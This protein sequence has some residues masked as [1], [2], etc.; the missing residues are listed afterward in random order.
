MKRAFRFCLL[1]LLLLLPA[2]EADA[3]S[4][5]WALPPQYDELK[6]YS[7]DYYFCRLDGKWGLIDPRGRVV[8]P[9]AYDFIIPTA[10]NLGIFGVRSG[11]KYRL[12][13]IVKSSGEVL[14]LRREY[15]LTAYHTFSEHKLPVADAK[16][17]KGYL[18]DE[19]VEV[20]RCQFDVARPFREGFAATTSDRWVYY[21]T[22]SFDL[23]RRGSVLQIDFRNG[24]ITEGS[25]FRNGEAVIGYGDKYCV[26]NR[27]GEVL[28]PFRYSDWRVDRT[29]YT[30]LGPGETGQAAAS[31]E[32]QP[33][34]DPTITPFVRDG[35]YGYRSN[36]EV[37]VDAVFDRAGAFDRSGH[38]VAAIGGRQGILALIEG[39]YASELQASDGSSDVIRVER[40]HVIPACLCRLEVPEGAVD[41][42]IFAD[43]GTGRY[44][45]ITDSLTRSGNTF[46]GLIHPAPLR[47]ADSCIL[48]LR[49]SS[50]GLPVHAAE[51]RFAL[52]YL[53]RLRIYG[54][55]AATA[56]ADVD[57]DL[58]PVTATLHNDSNRPK[59]VTV[60]LTVDCRL[61]VPVSRTETVTIPA[62]GHVT[63]TVP[64]K[65]LRNE[66]A[67]ARVVASSGES[68]SNTVAL[69]ESY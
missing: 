58:Q 63:L 41:L 61:N 68:R 22:D 44:E 50:G 56:K 59:R 67:A 65:V 25:S 10:G 39:V 55:V 42:R 31:R 15:Y 30:I 43:R 47:N 36:G 5:V 35:R 60:T 4:V 46:S 40:G 12:S 7:A 13:G 2:L 52:E 18:N 16:G 20:V 64:V 3:R 54:P 48:K 45:E 37:V 21:I 17:R 69:R 51:R 38:A 29:D 28:R 62:N 6:P 14:L 66:T 11:T 1:F 26:I 23:D 32:P 34:T 9:A 49:V 53:R 19:G 33:E 8:L 27:R 24:E 57:T